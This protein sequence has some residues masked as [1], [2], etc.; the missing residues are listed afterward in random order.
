MKSKFC[1][2]TCASSVSMKS[3]IIQPEIYESS[4]NYSSDPPGPLLSVLFFNVFYVYQIPTISDLDG[5][6]KFLMLCKPLSHSVHSLPC[7]L[8]C[9]CRA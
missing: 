9:N 2:Y 8:S 5:S 3:N 7:C 1:P 6:T 4:L